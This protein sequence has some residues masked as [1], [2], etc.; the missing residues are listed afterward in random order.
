MPP[1]TADTDLERE[2]ADVQADVES[3]PRLARTVE[4][5]GKRF[6]IAEKVGLMPLMRF[7]HAA[8]NQDAAAAGDM[9]ALAAIYDM[10]KDCIYAGNGLEPGEDGYDGGDWKAFERHATETKADHDELLPVVTQVIEM[11]TARPTVPPSGSSAGPRQISGSSTGTSSA[12]R[13]AGSNGSRRG[14]R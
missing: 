10:L 2:L 7:A 3:I 13:A 5:K 6:R 4:F 14:K 1:T 11:M 9:D 8:S 12:A